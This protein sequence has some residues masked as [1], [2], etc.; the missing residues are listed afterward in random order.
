[1]A[2]KRK[3]DKPELLIGIIDSRVRKTYPNETPIEPPPSNL[4]IAHLNYKFDDIDEPFGDY[5]L[6][7]KEIAEKVLGDFLRYRE[8]IE[9][10]AV[11]CRMGLGRSPAVAAALNECFSLGADLEEYFGWDSS[12]NINAYRTICRTAKEME[13]YNGDPKR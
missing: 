4:R 1:M 6:I 9:S 11:H 3:P 10:L 13:I 8:E 7:N 5:I 2:I 12:I